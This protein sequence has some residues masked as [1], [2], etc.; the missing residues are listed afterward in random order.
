MRWTLR[1]S[2]NG[3]MVADVD[4]KGAPSKWLTLRA[5]QALSHFEA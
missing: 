5:L 4:T 2:L 3:K 1:N